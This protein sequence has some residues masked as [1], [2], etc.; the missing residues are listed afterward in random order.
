MTKEVWTLVPE[1]SFKSSGGDSESSFGMHDTNFLGTGKYVAASYQQDIDR[2]KVK[3]EYRD[4]NIKGRHIDLRGL[5]EDSSDG[6]LRAVRLS[7]PFFSLNAK[8]SWGSHLIKTESEVSQYAFGEKV[9]TIAIDNQQLGF[10]MGHSEGLVNGQTH[11]WL[12]GVN[13]YDESYAKADN[14]LKPPAIPNDLELLYPYIEYQ[15]V[16]DKYWETYNIHKIGR[17]E[18][19]HVGR[20][21]RARFGYS[22]IDE[23]RLLFEGEW[24][25]TI[26][27]KRKALL[28]SS[29]EWSGRWNTET[30]TKEDIRL[31]FLLNLHRGQTDTRSLVM[32]LEVSALFN[33]PDF[34]QITLGGSSGLR[35]YETRYFA[36]DTRVLLSI[37]ERRYTRFEPFKLFRVGF[38]AFADIG[39]AWYR[40]GDISEKWHSD[41]GFGLRLM[42]SKSNSGQIIHIDLAYPINF[43]SA[44]SPQ[45]SVEVK[46][47]L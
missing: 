27:A 30:Q 6:F 28:Q 36:G 46:K 33:Q 21:L 1:L 2:D 24:R 22:P 9:S 16:E 38:A 18:D 42:P 3:L 10:F 43:D 20:Y 11:R 4:R 14:G 26:I 40:D 5:L 31:D 34:R 19:I 39:T 13:W 25:E 35:G 47:T 8:R 17:S 29:F 23:Q 37:E 15:Q 7:L 32:R 44:K 41:V 12:Y 45:L